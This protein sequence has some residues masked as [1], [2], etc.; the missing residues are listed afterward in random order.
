MPGAGCPYLYY[1]ERNAKHRRRRSIPG[2]VVTKQAGVGEDLPIIVIEYPGW[3][4]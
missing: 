4:F 3:P 1:Y 2:I